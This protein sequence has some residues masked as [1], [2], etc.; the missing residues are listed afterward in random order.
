LGGGDVGGGGG[1]GVGGGDGEVEFEEACV[2][3]GVRGPGEEDVE[4]A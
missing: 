3:G 1:W 2:E 4:V